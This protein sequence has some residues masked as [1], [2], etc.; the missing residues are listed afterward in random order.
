MGKS[1][2]GLLNQ[3]ESISLDTKKRMIKKCNNEKASKAGNYPNDIRDFVY[4]PNNDPTIL[5]DGEKQ[6]AYGVLI[7]FRDGKK[8]DEDGTV[9]RIGNMDFHRTLP[10]HTHA[11]QVYDIVNKQVVCKLNPED[12]NLPY[13]GKTAAEIKAAMETPTN[14]I[15]IHVDKFYCSSKVFT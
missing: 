2:F 3:V 15:E 12:W 8:T 4:D 6:Y 14:T 7:D 11:G 5:D 10:C 9:T 13:D 1:R